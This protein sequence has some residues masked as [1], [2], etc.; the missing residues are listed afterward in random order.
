MKK[1][2]KSPNT[3]IHIN[4]TQEL[5]VPW[6]KTL[7]SRTAA[8]G[9]MGKALDEVHGVNRT[10]G[11]HFIQDYS[12]LASNVSGRP[13]LSRSD[14]DRHRP[15]EA[16]PT[17]HKD[18]INTVNHVYHTVGLIR[19]IIDL[20]GDFAC[21]GVRISHPNEKIQK[22]YRNWFEK[23]GGKDRSERFLNNLYR[24]GNVVVRRMTAKIS[25]KDKE[26]M[27]K[28][29]AKPDTKIEF[30]KV[31][32][33]EIPWRYVFIDPA[34]VEVAC[35]PLSC[36]MGDK[37]YFLTLPSQLRHLINS[38]ENTGHQKHLISQLPPDVKEAAKH[39]RGWPLDPDKTLVFH[40]KKDDWQSWALPMIYAILKDIGLL[41]K[42]KLADLA[43]LD[44]AI[45]N[46]RIFK[47]GS[48]EHQIAPTRAGAA[49]L[50]EVLESHT[51][52]GTMDFVWGPDIELIETTTEVHKFL[53]EDKYI[54]TLNSIYAGLG[55][56]PTLTG[57]FGAAGTTNNF[58]SLQTLVNRLEYGR[59]VLTSFWKNEIAIVQK[60]MGFRQPAKMEFEFTNLGDV[61]AEKALLVDLSDRGIISEE[62][63]HYRLNSDAEL[64]RVRVNREDKMRD[65]DRMTKKASP[66]HDPQLEDA[67]VK[68]FAQTGAIA[69]SEVGI[70]L[71]PKKKGEK[72]ALDM[73]AQ[74]TAQ[75]PTKVGSPGRPKNTKDKK[76]RKT[77]TFKPK[78]KAALLWAQKAQE[79]ISSIAN[80]ILLSH[81]NKKDMR[82]LTAKEQQYCEKV[83]FGVLY[84]TEAFDDISEDTIYASL[85]KG[86]VPYS[87]NKEVQ[88]LMLGISNKLER[89]LT[90][91]EQRTIQATI[92][93]AY[94]GEE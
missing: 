16:I 78:S 88:Q 68:V 27:S 79:D 12:D 40:Y 33:N 75:K 37:R 61:A 15:H 70:E 94:Q 11:S 20:M 59:D 44:G 76:P 60:A 65:G 82:S 47:L 13:G 71:K 10:Q 58:I 89:S 55:I 17:K 24:T 2:R 66:Y 56:P 85:N 53:G 77:K 21:Q 93:A 72:S 62:L 35:G 19:N 84:N 46:I 63:L 83:K 50:A 32:A 18:I 86:G 14:Y 69:P 4:P 41:E 49:K 87:I 22:F 3:P 80:P 54:P 64:E 73:R 74:Q 26:R 25:A 28:T 48:L 39:N 57:T 51:G 42:L 6:N 31:P 81:F 9:E 34:M 90:L 29:T 38:S 92:Y 52:V 43:A 7:A 91:E 45:S 5:Y 36:F 23:V 30:E 1:D 8:F 67:L